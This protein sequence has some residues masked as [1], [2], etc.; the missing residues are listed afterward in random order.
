[1]YVQVCKYTHI[2]TEAHRFFK[3][4]LSRKVSRTINSNRTLTN[5]NQGIKKNHTA[6]KTIFTLKA[7]TTLVII[8]LLKNLK[9]VI[10]VEQ[11]LNDKKPKIPNPDLFANLSILEY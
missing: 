7:K 3:N 5:T 2:H 8:N 9:A 1:M 11:L 4:L 10:H 6:I